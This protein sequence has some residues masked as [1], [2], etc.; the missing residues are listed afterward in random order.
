MKPITSASSA[1]IELPT[2]ERLFEVQTYRKVMW[3]IVPLLALGYVF[4]IVDRLNIGIAKLQMM[5]ALGFSEAVYGFGAGIFFIGYLI[6]DVPSNLMLHRFGARRWLARIMVTWGVISAGT[7]F[8]SASWAFYLVRFALGAAEAGFFAGIL[9][10]TTYWFPASRRARIFALLLFAMPVSAIISGGGSGWL[11]SFANGWHG[12]AGWQWVF[13]LEGVPSIVLGM[14]TLRYLDD[15]IAGARWLKTEEKHLLTR[16]LDTEPARR[17]GEGTVLGALRSGR[18]WLLCLICFA[19]SAGMYGV[20]FWLPT[21]VKSSGILDIRAI[22]WFSALPWVVA[23]VPLWFVGRSADARGE[24]RWHVAIPLG[25]CGLGLLGSILFSHQAT[26]AILCLTCATCGVLT[27]LALFWS[28][29]TAFLSG[30]GAAAGIA[31]INSI[32][33]LAG[34]VFPF[35]I[36]VIKVRTGSLDGG[37]LLLAIVILLGACL[38][39]TLDKKVVNDA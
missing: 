2:D 8:V 32:G 23:L 12:L 1:M 18:V 7:A 39:L 11:M 20:G 19:I 5:P 24:R 10:Y 28:L 15:G 22:G 16:R 30:Y 17:L 35:L 26:M 38:V 13:I 25:V 36:G 34:F 37:V 3:R 14:V 6:F 29:P 33:S 31:L 4:S 9:L 21:L 27:S